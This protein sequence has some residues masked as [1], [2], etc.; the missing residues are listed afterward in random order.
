MEQNRGYIYTYWP[1]I[2]ILLLLFSTLSLGHVS[3]ELR[4]HSDVLKVA[5]LDI[6]QGDSIYIEAP[7][8]RQM[9]IDAGPGSAVLSKL[10]EIMPFYDRSIDILLATHTD[11]DHIG[12]F[13]SVFNHYDIGLMFE[14][15]AE[16]STATYQRL[17]ATRVAYGV[18]K[19]IARKGTRIVLDKEK[20]VYVDILFPDRDVSHMDSNDG[21]IVCRLVYGSESFMLTGDATMKTEKWIM[22]TNNSEVGLHSNI[23]K[24]GHHGSK[25]SSSMS[26]LKTI[27]PDEAIISAGLYNKYGHPAQDTLDRLARLHIPYLSTLGKGSILFETDGKSIKEVQG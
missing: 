5:F 8:G 7:N 3:L 10:A 9:L 12:G 21:S 25:Y 16:G 1:H 14:N 22:D 6:G 17:E 20:N 27:H 2:S 26:W 24:L 18:N 23:L 13:S 19:L 11:A 4:R 15:G